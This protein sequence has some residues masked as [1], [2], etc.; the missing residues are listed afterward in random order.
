MV[1]PAIS[2]RASSV[3]AFALVAFV[4]VRADRDLPNTGMADPVALE[5]VFDRFAGGSQPPN[6]A[7]LSLG[8]L[9]G[10]STEAANAGGR[11]VVDLATGVVSSNLQL[12]PPTDMFDLWL[13]DN[14]PS[15]GHSTLA[16]PGDGLLKIGTYVFV[17]GRH[18]LTAPLGAAAFAS[19]YPDR[20]FVVRSGSN[21]IEGFVLTGTDTLFARLRHR[22]VRFLDAADAPLG[23][24]PTAAARAIDFAKVTADGRQLFVQET[25]AGNGRTCG[26]CHIETNN[27]TV[28]PKVIATLSPD[29][30]LFVAETKPALTDLENAHLLRQFGLILVNAD[31]FDPS[32]GHVFRSTQNTQ[33]LLNSMTPQDPSFGIDFST[34]GRNPNPPERLGWGNDGAP[35]RDFTLVAI[36]QHFPKSLGRTRGVDFRM[37]TDEELDALAAYQ[38]SLGRQEDFNLPA[39]ELNSTLATIGKRLFLDSGDLFE[40]GAGHKNCNGCHFNGGGSAG[41]SFNDATPGFPDIDGSPRGFNIGAAT[42]ANETPLALSLSLPRDGGFGQLLTAFGSFGNLDDL[43]PPF[44]HLEFEEFNSPP[45]VESADT[46]P[47]FHNHTIED[48]ESAVAFYG[49]PAFQGTLQAS[50]TPVSI[51]ADPRDPEVQAIS[52]FLRVLNALENIRSSIDTAMRGRAMSRAADLNDLARLSLAETKDALE[53]LSEGALAAHKEPGLKS[54]RTEL[55][56]ARVAL[57]VA[58]RLPNPR[59]IDNHLRTAVGHLRQARSALANQATLPPSFRN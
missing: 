57:D 31:G 5:H 2:T 42:N 21:P 36:A 30:P 3:V 52:A 35:L 1:S 18:R 39:L 49:T 45:V 34:N 13:V 58:Q 12:L 41:M 50:V 43:P 51:S 29:D 56:S 6:V 32:R 38:L 33:A 26:T 27:F 4:V 11:V 15:D 40:T 24:D 46:G 55:H 23:I 10:V 44:G 14:R 53:V 59:A 20:A 7:V 16:E 54:A 9:R 17:A 37:P 28:D 25:F 47:F 48:L 8:N 19:F 22:Q